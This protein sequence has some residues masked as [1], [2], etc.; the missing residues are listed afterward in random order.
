MPSLG[1][2]SIILDL[3]FAILDLRFAI[4]DLRFVE[5]GGTTPLW[6]HDGKCLGQTTDPES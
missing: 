2:A 4:C 1:G 3:R 6:L 5:C